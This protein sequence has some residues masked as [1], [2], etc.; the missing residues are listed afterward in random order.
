MPA[1]TVSNYLRRLGEPSFVEDPNTGLKRLTRRYI[2][3]T[4]GVELA[5]L[6]SQVFD[7]IGNNDR[8]FASYYLV[9]QRI[10]TA[11]SEGDVILT[12]VFQE[13]DSGSG[14]VKSG[15]DDIERL[16][17]DL[18]RVTQTF[19][20]L[21]GSADDIGNLDGDVGTDTYVI[22]NTS[23]SVTV[24]LA[25]WKR[26]V[27][28][29]TVVRYTKVYQQKGILRVDINERYGKT[30][31]NKLD[32]ANT[33]TLIEY[34]VTGFLIDDSDVTAAMLGDPYNDGTS[35]PP[36]PFDVSTNNYHGMEVVRLRYVYGMGIIAA[37]KSVK[38]GVADGVVE[39]V[40]TSINVSPSEWLKDG[41]SITYDSTLYNAGWLEDVGLNS[42][43]TDA[44]DDYILYTA[45]YISVDGAAGY[46][47]G[48][49]TG[50]T[51]TT[52]S[53]TIEGE[54]SGFSIPA[55]SKLTDTTT[56]E[57]GGNVEVRRISFIVELTAGTGELDNLIGGVASVSGEENYVVVGSGTKTYPGYAVGEF[58]LSR[59][60]GVVSVTRD[61]R[62]ADVRPG[63]DG[64]VVHQ[65]TAIN[66][67]PTQVGVF[68]QGGRTYDFTDAKAISSTVKDTIHG[69]LY[70]ME[71][72]A[73]SAI[74]GLSTTTK[75]DG[76]LEITT[77]TGLNINPLDVYG[78]TYGTV[79]NHE[80]TV[81]QY[82]TLYKYVFAKGQGEILR[83]TESRY[84]QQVTV[85]TVKS[86]NEQPAVPANAYLISTQ[87][88]SDDYG[89]IYTYVWAEGSGVIST[90]TESRYNGNLTIYTVRTINETFPVPENAYLL[91]TKF[92][93]G[94]Y[95]EVWTVRYA[96]G[97]GLIKESTQE[98]YDGK[99]I[100]TTAQYLNEVPSLGDVNVISTSTETSD[101]GIVYTYKYAEGQGELET[102][103]ETRYN[104]KVR[105]YTT[106]WLNQVPEIPDGYIITSTKIESA[107][108]GTIYTYQYVD[109][110]V[111][112]ELSRSER[113]RYNEK[114]KI[115]KI[116]TLGAP[117]EI[118]GTAVTVTEA[119]RD[120]EY[121]TIYTVEYAEGAG[122]VDTKTE[123][124]YLDEGGEAQL[125]IISERWLNVNPEL[126]AG[127][128]LLSEG[129]SE[130][131]YGTLYTIR[132]ASGSGKLFEGVEERYD[133]K[134]K[135][136]TSRWLNVEADDIPEGAAIISTNTETS[137]YG[138]IYT[139]KYAIGSPGFLEESISYR[140]DGAL[141]IT[142]R[143]YLNVKPPDPSSGELL[144]EIS[145]K[146][147]DYGVIY[148][149]TVA[150]GSGEISRSET[151]IYPG[152][153]TR[154][155]AR[156]LN[157]LPE[158]P[159]DALV[160]SDASEDGTYGTFYTTTYAT[161]PGGRID[162]ASE[163]RYDGDLT[164][165]TERWIRKAPVVGTRTLVS[166]STDTTQY[167]DI[168]TYKFAEGSG[169]ITEQVEN[170]FGGV[171]KIYTRTYLNEEP[172]IDPD[173]DVL[174]S[175]S[176]E[177]TSFG[178]LYRIK[179]AQ[180]QGLLSSNTST[181][182]NGTLTITTDRY[183]NVEGA[184]PDST[185]EIS[186]KA[187]QEEYGVVY[188]Y[189]Y[190]EGSGELSRTE[191]SKFL[192]S[193]TGA[194]VPPTSLP[195]VKAS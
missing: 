60:S 114:L 99:L 155:V 44:Q 12:R 121:G 154:V 22:P 153:L 151:D 177:D 136:Y 183:L 165:T 186:T 78:T 73:G 47:G 122:L 113:Y 1:V 96:E 174:L 2:V 56:L 116:E 40:L 112:I 182:F 131:T 169:L 171:L 42:I 98:R 45:R 100:I 4:E 152:I 11:E 189:V 146:D 150:E 193:V 5:N 188:E 138:T 102:K 144:V 8:E 117:A 161:G 34:T 32:A 66:V 28:S 137:D 118:P 156:Y 14:L 178:S 120:G 49:A 139:Y 67:N 134:L 65:V 30:P 51:V 140:Y 145:E 91:S 23:P 76:Q 172:A 132:Y 163:S 159:D 86:L 143:T 20:G 64:G 157:A 195:R 123:G 194:N 187:T 92:E 176:T 57:Y 24:V 167:G 29:D 192:S 88:N 89:D 160:I 95:G 133:G 3:D 105:L 81:N 46:V 90:E 79:A 19:I 15:G 175:Y 39:H 38:V 82:G 190:A 6:E 147:T 104:G 149:Q 94:N 126:P 9:E 10:D 87:I 158:V 142:R 115:T 62:F 83:K 173:N 119:T 35:K 43:T 54:W 61:S 170:R 181:R 53:I 135:I 52:G 109:G 93:E 128:T 129:L 108:Y 48:S 21:N 141:K 18:Y 111:A 63:E 77:I 101:Y 166:T 185:F 130:E 84:D 36:G 107:D 106:V 31:F 72:Y 110:S 148:S 68:D 80:V 71:I 162:S 164:L 50:G 74:T 191:S 16:D 103:E 37:S 124:K 55:D 33:P 25:N 13:L 27:I 168:V 69:P 26:E 85:T 59:G 41:G 7:T 58:T 127:A 184:I 70:T 179:I 180:G 125:T 97:S 75:Y 17:N